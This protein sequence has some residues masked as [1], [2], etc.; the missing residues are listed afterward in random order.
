LKPLKR[1]FTTSRI[2][3]IEPIEENQLK[4]WIKDKR[5]LQLIGSVGA[6]I[7]KM[8]SQ[9][10]NDPTLPNLNFQPGTIA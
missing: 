8:Q 6:D 10:A 4:D 2:E 5:S 7:T 9:N 3:A 1:L